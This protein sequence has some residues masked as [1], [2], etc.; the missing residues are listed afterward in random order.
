MKNLRWPKP[1]MAGD[2]VALTATSSPVPEKNL[3]AAIKSI[4][5]LGL[6]PTV[7]PS[8]RM[9]HGYMAGPDEQRAADLN[10]AF[11]AAD[12]KGVFCL[13]GG[14]GM[15]RILPLLD[16]EVIKNN[17]KVFVGYSDVTA[18]HTA[19][20]NLCGFITFHGPMPN[21]DY[22]R[23]DKFTM[24]SLQACLFSPE[25]L[26]S[27]ENPPHRQMNILKPGNAV[28]ALTGG[29]LSLLAATLGS[30]YEIDAKDKILFIEDVGERPYRLDKALTALS[31][32]GKF[33][34][35]N[36]II[37]GSFAECEEPEPNKVPPNTV[38][39]QEAL[40]L[41]EIFK[42]VILPWDKPT[43]HNLRVGHIY[44]QS[45]L[46][47]GAEISLNM[48]DIPKLSLVQQA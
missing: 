12:I 35:C 1:L 10:D 47:M 4:E 34:D 44:P 30:P 5:H 6:I 48:T 25:S 26:T 11:A 7:M 18:L 3:D 39:A 17:H 13:R 43:L 31:L 42:E 8:C 24:N 32:A 16:F 21:T 23:L 9:S 41:D 38:I 33:K 15:T 27:I 28:G 37:L 19:I 45:T 2:K 46:P 40:T 29:N 22:R 36:G 20:N 14:Y